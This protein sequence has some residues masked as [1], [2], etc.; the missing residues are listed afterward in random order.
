MTAICCVSVCR[1]QCLAFAQPPPPARPPRCPGG[2]VYK[3]LASTTTSCRCQTEPA[4]SCRSRPQLQ[5][6]ARVTS[7][8]C[9]DSQLSQLMK[10][11]VPRLAAVAGLAWGLQGRGRAGGVAGAG[12]LRGARHCWSWGRALPAAAAQCHH[13]LSS[14]WC[15]GPGQ[16]SPPAS[17][18]SPAAEQCLQHPRPSPVSWA[19]PGPDTPPPPPAGTHRAGTHQHTTGA[20]LCAVRCVLPPPR[21]PGPVSPLNQRQWSWCRCAGGGVCPGCAR[22]SRVTL[23]FHSWRAGR[24]LAARPAL[25]TM[26]S[27]KQTLALGHRQTAAP[28][29]ARTAGGST[30]HPATTFTLYI[31][32]SPRPACKQSH[33]AAPRGSQVTESPHKRR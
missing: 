23:D 24:C 13:H 5:L 17:P 14:V 33:P 2:R 18:P 31:Q 11:A 25:G 16:P 22:L 4:V 28:A 6:R 15:A 9:D 10:S 30:H 3:G 12:Q 29:R 20:G 21:P 32:P 26:P 19:A 1:T 8:S 7:G 27:N